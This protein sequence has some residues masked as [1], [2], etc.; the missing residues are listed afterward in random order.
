MAHLKG[1]CR[2]AKADRPANSVSEV[3]AGDGRIYK[4]G[5]EPIEDRSIALLTPDSIPGGVWDRYASRNAGC[6]CVAFGGCSPPLTRGGLYRFWNSTEGKRRLWEVVVECL[7]N[8]IQTWAPS[9]CYIIDTQCG[10]RLFFP[11]S[12]ERE[13]FSSIPNYGEGDTKAVMYTLALKEAYG[14]VLMCSIDWDL[15]IQVCFV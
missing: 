10:R 3:L 2:Y 5:L 6:I 14:P 11:P 1:P 8:I 13:A 4:R 12:F 9:K 7:V 15:A